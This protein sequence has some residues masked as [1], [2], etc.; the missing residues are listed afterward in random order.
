MKVLVAS[1]TAGVLDHALAVGFGFLFPAITY[2]LYARRRPALHAE[3]PGARMR[4]YRDTILGLA[5]MGACTLAVWWLAGRPWADLG[6][7]VPTLRAPTA[8]ASL[9]VLLL[10]ALFAYQLRLIR[11][12]PRAQEAVRTQA[13]AVEEFLPTTE[14]EGRRFL[15]IAVSAGIGEELFYRGFLV[16]YLSALLPALAAIG[17]AATVF[18]LAH[19]MHGVTNTYRAGLLGLLCSGLYAWTDALWVPMFL[20]TLIDGF[21]GRASLAARVGGRLTGAYGHPADHHG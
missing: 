3:F 9:A 14:P 2:R 20:H 15:W 13:A 16:W 4:E 7:G 8:I 12:D 10:A 5:A 11:S 17:V 21:A 18:A 19:V 1:M 6:L